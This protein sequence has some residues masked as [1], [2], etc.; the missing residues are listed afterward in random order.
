[1][2]RIE[3]AEPMLRID[4][5]DPMLRIDP[6]EPELRI[7]ESAEPIGCDRRRAVP[8]P[9]FSQSSPASSAL[10]ADV[11]ELTEL[12]EVPWIMLNDWRMAAAQPVT[13]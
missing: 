9:A 12:S 7:D 2:L 4:P 8:I 6:A 13:P 5:A 11:R 10:T 3:P 1:M